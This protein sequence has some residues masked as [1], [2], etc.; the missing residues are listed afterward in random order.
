MHGIFSMSL[1]PATFFFLS[2]SL[3]FVSNSVVVDIVIVGINWG[4]VGI[5][6]V[7]GDGSI[8]SAMGSGG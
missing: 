3:M 4:G 7:S 5:L 6:G 1:V 8:G 2:E